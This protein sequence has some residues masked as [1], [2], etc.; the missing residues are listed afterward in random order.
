MA[1]KIIFEVFGS[2]FYKKSLFLF[3]S[4]SLTPSPSNA[5][6]PPPSVSFSKFIHTSTGPYRVSVQAQPQTANISRPKL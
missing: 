6:S 3:Q 1:T 4:F 5:F 2:H